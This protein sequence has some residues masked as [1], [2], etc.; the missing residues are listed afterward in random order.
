MKGKRI[1]AVHGIRNK[2][3][4]IATRDM[5]VAT[6]RMKDWKKRYEQNEF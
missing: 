4:S 3:Q 5:E 1:V 2:G 6:E